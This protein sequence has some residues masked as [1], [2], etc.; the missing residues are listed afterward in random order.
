MNKGD[1]VLVRFP[2]TDFGGSKL[3]P[4]VVLVPENDYGDICLA[5]ITS[6]TTESD[7]T[8]LDGLIIDEREKEFART[9]LKT[10]S[11][12]MAGKI[13]TLQK[14]LIA[15]KIGSLSGGRIKKLNKILKQIFQIK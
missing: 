14:R 6:K 3:R 2:F 12:I 15:G 10:S 4:A 7:E 13:V 11:M 9:G 5:F 8:K 1:I